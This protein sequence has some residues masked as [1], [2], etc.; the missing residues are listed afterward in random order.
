MNAVPRRFGLT[1]LW[2]LARDPAYADFLKE[3]AVSCVQL[4]FFGMEGTTDRYV[5]CPY[6]FPKNEFVIIIQIGLAKTLH[7]AIM[8]KRYETRLTFL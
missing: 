3:A 6:L 4:T 1:S 2:R 5:R 8:M 7:C